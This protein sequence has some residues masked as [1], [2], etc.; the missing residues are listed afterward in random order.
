MQSMSAESDRLK[1]AREA[2]GIPS[3]AAAADRFGWKQPTYF[4]HENGSRGFKGV[5]ET[6]ARAFRTTPEWLLFGRGS[7]RPVTVRYQEPPAAQLAEAV[8]LRN[9]PAR[10]EPGDA[11]PPGAGLIPV[12]DVTASAGPGTYIDY[13]FVAY[14]LAFPA[15]YIRHLTTTN[16][17][18]LAIISVKGDS[19]E[20]TLKTD[21]IVMLDTT[22]TDASYDGI[23]VYREGSA[24]HVKRFGRSSHPGFVTV[25]SDNRVE[26]PPVEKR[27]D[28]IDV[29]GKVIW[30]G[31]KV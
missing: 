29:L 25:H 20:P 30:Y 7:M 13:E 23:F 10:L 27:M 14:S 4:A 5:A 26:Y 1:A 31:K 24:L 9:S 18:F 28:A 8:D 21:D 17:K 15:N 22:K 19:M 11:V 16:M 2:A 3:A 12:Y 6:Y